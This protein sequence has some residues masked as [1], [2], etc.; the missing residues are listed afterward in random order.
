M[1]PAGGEMRPFAPNNNNRSVFNRDRAAGGSG[2]SGSG[3]L[4]N[5]SDRND[6]SETGQN[7]KTAGRDESSGGQ[8]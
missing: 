7:E 3:W 6:G 8:N 4:E 2:R 1:P 5:T